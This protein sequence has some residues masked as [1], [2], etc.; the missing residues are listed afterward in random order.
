MRKLKIA[1]D[2]DN[3]VCD[4]SVAVVE[5]INER[6]PVNL[7]LESLSSY[8]IENFLP[9]QYKWIVETAFNDSSMWRRVKLIDGAAEYIEKLYNEGNEIYFATATTPNNFKKK[10]GFL[11]R[12]F[13]FFPE[14]YVKNNTICIK[15]KQILDVHYLI[16]DSLENLVGPR[17]Y[18]SICFDYPWNRDIEYESCFYRVKSW[19]E[20]YD[21][22]LGKHNIKIFFEGDRH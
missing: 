2:I 18:I 21:R 9:D 22:I 14:G 20:I 17:S 19:K 11:E 8:W 7:E 6:L 1:I 3:V 13:P 15:N 4:T 16:D 12:S 5:Y 10:I